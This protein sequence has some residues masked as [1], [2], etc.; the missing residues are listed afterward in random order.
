VNVLG[1]SSATNAL[2]LLGVWL[3]LAVMIP[4]TL[5]TTVMVLHPSPSRVELVTATREA[6]NTAS[7][8]GAQ[9]LALYYQDHPELMAGQAP[10]MNDFA[11]RSLAVGDEVAR[12]TRPIVERF[13]TALVRQQRVVDRWRFV[14]PAVAAHDALIRLAGTD[15]DRFRDFQRQAD[16]YATAIKGYVAPLMSQKAHFTSTHLS[17]MPAF[18]FDETAAAARSGAAGRTLAAMGGMLLGALILAACSAALLRRV[19]FRER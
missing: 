13:D 4:A 6:S 11:A 17:G 18:A 3:V 10:D 5:A 1:R 9:L 16:G 15:G 19:S 12:I 2:A 8:R 7:A 14:S